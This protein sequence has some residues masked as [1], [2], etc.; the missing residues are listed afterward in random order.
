MRRLALALLLLAAAGHAGIRTYPPSGG[1]VGGGGGPLPDEYVP[2]GVAGLAAQLQ[3]YWSFNGILE[4]IGS[5]ATHLNYDSHTG[6]YH[7]QASGADTPE[8]DFPGI[9]SRKI[10]F[11][12]TEGSGDPYTLTTQSFRQ[13]GDFS[14]S[15]WAQNNSNGELTSGFPLLYFR[16]TDTAGTTHDYNLA[17]PGFSMLVTFTAFDSVAGST[18]VSTPLFALNSTFHNIVISYNATTRI[19]TMYYDGALHATSAALANGLRQGSTKIQTYNQGIGARVGYD[20]MGVW[21]RAL[22]LA[23][24]VS[25]YNGGVG[26]AY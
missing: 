8:S 15:V 23:D 6:G 22:T 2:F 10:M 9:L 13:A 1:G 24:A 4:T 11:N 14:I 18:S 20:E 21:Q 17:A 16:A 3:A 5:D 19:A 25:I 12:N 26:R 7:W